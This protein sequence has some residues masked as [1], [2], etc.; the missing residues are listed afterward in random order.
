MAVRGGD[1]GIEDQTRA[2]CYVSER[3]EDDGCEGSLKPKV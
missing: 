2:A 3:C 1:K